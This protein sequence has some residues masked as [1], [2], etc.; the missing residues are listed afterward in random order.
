[1]TLLVVDRRRDPI[2][3]RARRFEGDV[4]VGEFALHQLEGP[5]RHAELSSFPHV[6]Q[7][8][9]E[10]GLHDPDR[11]AAENE[12]FGVQA[13]HQHAHA[14]TRLAEHMVLGD[15]T[16]LEEQ[17]ARAGAAHPELVQVLGR[18]EPGQPRSITK[19]VIGDG[20]PASSVRM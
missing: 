7:H 19:A 1:M 9:V 8:Q 17:L 15:Q 2:R 11:A 16:V 14:V 6:W 3:E 5:D 20:P 13:G 4:H 18:A 10:R 12:P